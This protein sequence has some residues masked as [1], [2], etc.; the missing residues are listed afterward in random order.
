VP[1]NF[2]RDYDREHIQG[3]EETTWHGVGAA[4]ELTFHVRGRDVTETFGGAY[5]D[6]QPIRIDGM[7]VYETFFNETFVSEFSFFGAVG[8]QIPPGKLPS[9]DRAEL[10]PIKLGRSTQKLRCFHLLKK[11]GSKAA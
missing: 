4:R 7:I 8:P 3:L 9:G 5:A 2:D 6:K 11:D 10:T 1:N